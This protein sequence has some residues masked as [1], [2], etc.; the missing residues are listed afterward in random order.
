MGAELALKKEKR[1]V[2]VAKAMVEKKAR[3]N[4]VEVYLRKFHNG[5]GLS[6]GIIQ[7]V[8]RVLQ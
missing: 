7:D 1:E 2:E 4:V 5:E 8:G 6:D 3:E